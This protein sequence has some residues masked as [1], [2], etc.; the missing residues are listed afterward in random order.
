MQK[1]LGIWGEPGKGGANPG[2][3]KGQAGPLGGDEEGSQGAPNAGNLCFT[4][5]RPDQGRGQ[6][7]GAAWGPA[8]RAERLDLGRKEGAESDGWKTEGQG[9]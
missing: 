4:Q 2:P 5:Q 7:R 6:L 3:Q 8:G 9:R 1:T